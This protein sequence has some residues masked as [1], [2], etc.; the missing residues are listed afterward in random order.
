MIEIESKIK[1][2]SYL[3]GFAENAGKAQKIQRDLNGLIEQLRLGNESPGIGTST[4][5]KGVK[6]ARALSGARVYFRK[7]TE[8]LKY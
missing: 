3:V 4:L 7:K 1:E 2:D 6:E 8:I 5:F